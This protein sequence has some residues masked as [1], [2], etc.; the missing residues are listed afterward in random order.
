MVILLGVLPQFLKSSL[1]KSALHQI[2]LDD[3]FGFENL[4]VGHMPTKKVVDWTNALMVNNNQQ[5]YR[6]DKGDFATINQIMKI[7]NWES[8][9]AD[10][11]TKM[12]RKPF[13]ENYDA[14]M[15]TVKPNKWRRPSWR[16]GHAIKTTKKSYWAC[17]QYLNVKKMISDTAG[18]VTRCRKSIIG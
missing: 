2:V 14:A 7:T 8:E 1:V 17:N 5:M 12:A 4:K 16:N 13:K 6:M 18:N 11:N 3:S 9:E 15:D 10:M